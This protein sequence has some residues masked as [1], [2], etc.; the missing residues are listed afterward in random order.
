VADLRRL[1]EVGDY[2]LRDV[3]IDPKLARTD[4]SAT[5]EHFLRCR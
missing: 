1:A 3:G 4:P 5:A 2:L